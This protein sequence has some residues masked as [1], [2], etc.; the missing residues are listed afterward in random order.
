MFQLSNIA[1][2]DN[3]IHSFCF[4]CIRKWSRN[5][6]ACPNCRS[7]FSEILHKNKFGFTCRF[8]IEKQFKEQVQDQLNL[9]EMNFL[10]PYCEI[11]G[12]PDRE[13]ELLVCDTCNY[14]I[15]HYQCDGLTGIPQGSWSCH[16]CRQ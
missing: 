2:L 4:K 3:C 1:N 16:R 6:S 5:S 12:F 10:A 7:E 13:D 9:N 8:K 15:C 14:N 11:C